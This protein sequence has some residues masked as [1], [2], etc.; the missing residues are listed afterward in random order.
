MIEVSKSS[1]AR[2]PFH[3]SSAIKVCFLLYFA[4]VGITTGVDFLDSWVNSFGFLFMAAFGILY[5]V[6]FKK[7]KIVRG[8]FTWLL[9]FILLY[10]IS[11]IWS[12]NADDLLYYSYRSYFFQIAVIAFIVE[13]D[14]NNKKDIEDYLRII[15]L[16]TIYMIIALLINTPLTEWGTERLGESIG[17]NSNSVGMRIAFS[18]VILFYFAEK[19][20]ALYVLAV[21]L[22]IVGLFSGSRK[23]LFMM[24]LGIVV[25]LI[26]GKESNKKIR[27]ILISL[28]IVSFILYEVMN[29]PV[30]YGV[31]GHRV[32]NA[33]NFMTDTGSVTGENSIIERSFYRKTAMHMFWERPLLGWGG[34]GFVTRMRDMN[35]SHVAYSH[36]NYTEMLADLGLVGF[37]FYYSLQARILINAFKNR[38]NDRI[39]IVALSITIANLFGEYF[40]VSYIDVYTQTILLLMF[41]I[42]RLPVTNKQSDLEMIYE[43]N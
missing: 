15:L 19:K 24:L 31:L 2:I 11:I 13:N 22:A 7:G 43:I 41:V 6:R 3:L 34:N 40:Y 32:Q 23:S 37:I 1:K 38:W 16:A 18:I 39:Y 30:L 9:I 4:T 36:C 20:K 8:Y 28:L 10:Y 12:K 26:V 5:I 21:P 42:S 14:I 35:Y 17:M 29:N 25:F 27:N 33:L